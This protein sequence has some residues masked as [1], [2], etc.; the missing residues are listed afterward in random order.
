MSLPRYETTEDHYQAGISALAPYLDIESLRAMVQA[1]RRFFHI[2]SS[3]LWEDPVKCLRLSDTHSPFGQSESSPYFLHRPFQKNNV[4][5]KSLDLRPILH[6]AFKRQHERDYWNNEPDLNLETVL[7]FITKMPNLR[8][9]ILEKDTTDEKDEKE[10]ADTFTF[11]AS[12]RPKA[13]AKRP[14]ADDDDLRDVV[15]E[16]KAFRA[17]VSGEV[18]R[19]NGTLQLVVPFGGSR[20][21]E[22]A[23]AE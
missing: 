2:F 9:L 4:F 15:A 7:G 13:K 19:W 17:S 16:L 23:E 12:T 22:R 10:E 6:E 14:P 11:L 8:Y 20:S 3:Y 21:L 5:V 1:N 18:P